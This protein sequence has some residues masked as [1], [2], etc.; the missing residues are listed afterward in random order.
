MKAQMATKKLPKIKSQKKYELKPEE[1]RW[2][3]NPNIFEFD[4]TESLKPI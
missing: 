1:L 3:C 4:S 2:E